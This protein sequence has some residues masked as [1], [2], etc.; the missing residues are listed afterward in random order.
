[1]FFQQLEPGAKVRFQ[2]SNAVCPEKEDILES[3][4]EEL[5]VSGEVLYLSDSGTNRGQY[6]IVD[7]A[8]IMAP[9]IVPIDNI[10][11]FAAAAENGVAASKSE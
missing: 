4:T 1:M 5:K 7:V 10:E 9:I 2:L 6:A 3:I 11:K 8:G